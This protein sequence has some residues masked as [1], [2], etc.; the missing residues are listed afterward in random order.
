MIGFRGYAQRD[1]FPEYKTEA[2]AL[3]ESLLNSLRTEIS[4]KISKVHDR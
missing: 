3:F 1:P 4:E 2:F